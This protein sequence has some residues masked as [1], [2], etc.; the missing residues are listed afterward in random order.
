MRHA[1]LIWGCWLLCASADLFG[2][3]RGAEDFRLT[4]INRDLISTPEFSYSGARTSDTDRDARWLEVEAEFSAEPDFTDELTFRYFVL[5][6]GRLLSGEVTQVNIPAG[7][8]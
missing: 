2:Q 1:L 8:D 5:I 6:N 4:K 3:G 7:R